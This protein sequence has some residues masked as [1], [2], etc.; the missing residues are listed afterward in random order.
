MGRV[1]NWNGGPV[2]GI[3]I[4]LEDGWGNVYEAVSKSS[5]AD[6]GLFDFPLYSDAAQ[7]LR[8][9]V[10]DGGG[11]PISPTIV[12]PHRKSTENDFSCHYVTFQGG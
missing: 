10:L 12:V 7:D 8:I 2:A 11:S 5:T 3:R 4:R 1:I 9:L 6:Y